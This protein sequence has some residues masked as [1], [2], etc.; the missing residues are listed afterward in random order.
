MYKTTRREIYDD[1][2]NRP[3]GRDIIMHTRAAAPHA[4]IQEG[5]HVISDHVKSIRT[6][7]QH[8][9]FSFDTTAESGI[10]CL[11]LR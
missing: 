2:V 4:Y 1:S 6:Y 11:N 8:K 3:E 10:F 5:G 9:F 7:V